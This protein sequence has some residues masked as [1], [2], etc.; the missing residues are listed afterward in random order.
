MWNDEDGY[1]SALPPRATVMSA[2]IVSA[3]FSAQRSGAPAGPSASRSALV[4][5]S[6]GSALAGLTVATPHPGQA[7]KSWR[8]PSRPTTDRGSATRCRKRITVVL[9]NWRRLSAE[10]TTT[11]QRGDRAPPRN[12]SP[13]PG[14]CGPPWPPDLMVHTVAGRFAELVQIAQ[15]QA[16]HGAF[17]IEAGRAPKSVFH[18]G[19]QDRAGGQ[20]RGRIGPRLKA[21]QARELPVFADCE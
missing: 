14:E 17:T 7:W 21:R 5:T 16:D 6:R 9:T 19:E 11:K 4:I 12:E 15:M 18:L 13:P 1:C 20:A 8:A 3:A 10:I 2:G